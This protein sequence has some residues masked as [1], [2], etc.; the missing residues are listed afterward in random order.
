MEQLPFLHRRSPNQQLGRMGEVAAG[1]VRTR[2]RL[3]PSHRVEQPVA[4][5][6]HGK[7]YIEYRVVRSRNPN[8]ARRLQHPFALREPAG[9]EG[10]VLFETVALVPT[11][12]SDRCATTALARR[13]TIRQKV[14]RI[15]EHQIEALLRKSF[16]QFE[17]VAAEQLPCCASDTPGALRANMGNELHDYSFKRPTP[18]CAP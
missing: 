4:E 5:L 12:F 6:L 14:R 3:V 9:A 17:S 10:L 2:V 8:G 18:R 16:Q 11:S 15:R 1:E 13:S 7:T